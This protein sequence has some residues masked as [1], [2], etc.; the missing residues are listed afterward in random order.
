MSNSRAPD[1]RLRSLL[2][3]FSWRVLAT[4]T[5]GVIAYYITGELG[6]A[7]MIGGIEFFLKFFI[8]YVHERA[9][10]HI[11]VGKAPQ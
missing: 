9:W 1:S 11:Q 5:T 7:L 6:A 8:Y 10:Q 2:K 4:F 3:A